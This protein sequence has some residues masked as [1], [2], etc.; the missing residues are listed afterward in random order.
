MEP[1]QGTA[2]CPDCGHV[3]AAGA[4]RP[5]FVVT[6][7]SGSGKTAV[8]APLARLL[9]GHAVTFDVDWLIDAATALAGGRPVAWPAF[10][11]AWMSV[12]HGVAQCGTPTVLL[13]P[14]IPEH[15]QDL[16][17][18]RWVGTIHFLVLDCPDEVRRARIEA[19][20]AWRS[21]DVE[22]QVRFGRW[23]RGNIPDRVD[24]AR[25]T[26]EDTARSVATWV[27]RNIG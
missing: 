27:L 20:P 26:P 8:L 19:R 17:A 22:E 11:D 21:R 6:G 4:V 10:R 5:L 2:R 18:R 14:L 23:L 16:P 24:T 13:G 3:D 9:A 7:A 25:G 1:R 12:A 15:L